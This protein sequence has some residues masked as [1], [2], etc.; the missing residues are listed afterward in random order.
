MFSLCFLFHRSRKFIPLLL[1]SNQGEVITQQV[2]GNG[3]AV[4]IVNLERDATS[5]IKTVSASVIPKLGCFRWSP[6]RDDVISKGVHRFTSIKKETVWLAHRLCQWVKRRLCSVRR[7]MVH[8]LVAPSIDLDSLWS[9]SLTDSPVL[10]QNV[11]WNVTGSKTQLRKV[12]GARPVRYKEFSNF[13][14]PL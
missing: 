4:G 1:G 12:I 11:L 8:G 10:F 2:F 9:I 7:E 3:I 6:P 13:P 14:I 5:P